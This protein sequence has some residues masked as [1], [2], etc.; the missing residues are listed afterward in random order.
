MKK[1]ITGAAYTDTMNDRE[2]KNRKIAYEA[3]TEGI[4]LLKNDGAL[5]VKPGR[6][7][8]YGAGV[9]QT[10]KG[11]TGSGEVYTRRDI[12]I[13]EG[14]EN[15]GFEVTTKTWIADYDKAYEEAVEAH[16]E[17]CRKAF[18]DGLKGKKS[19][20]AIDPMS[21]QI[22]LPF[23]RLIT[24]KDIADSGCDTAVYVVARQAG[25]GADKRLDREDFDLAPV[26]V[27]NLKMISASYKKTVLVI[28]SG[29]YM[30]LSSIENIPVSAL[31]FFC[32]QGT[33]G[34]NA[35]ASIV[36]GKVNPSGKLVDT[37]CA[38]YADIPFGDQYSYLSG[39]TTQEY[40]R[41]GIYVGYRYF[42]TYRVKPRYP[43]GFG[44]S[45]TEFKL[46]TAH[47]RREKMDIVLQVAVTN[48]G[49]V[50]G[51]EV[52]QVYVSC[53]DGMLKKEYQRLVAF[54]KTKLLQSGETQTLEIRFPM[55]YCA[56]YDETGAA[57][58]LEKGNYIIRVGN[59][60]VQTVAA[61]VVALDNTAVISQNTNICK[62][63]TPVEELVPV[64][65]E[66]EDDLTNAVRICLS[67]D[68]IVTRVVSYKAPEIYHDEQVDAILKKLTVKEMATLCNGAGFMSLF[69]A[70][71]NATPGA[72][73]SSTY[74]LLNKG[75]INVNFSDGPAGLRLQKRSGI[76]KGGTIKMIDMFM[77]FMEYIPE[78]IKK[79]ICANPEKD[80][81]VYQF[82][83]A[84]PVG[85]SIAQSW[86]TEIAAEIGR[87]VSEEMREY[88]VTFWLAP[89]MN[90]H[91]NPLCGRNYEYFS[92]DPVISGKMAAAIVRGVQSIPGNYATPKHFCCNN[93]ED[94][95]T[96]SNSNV[97]ERA[98]RE[99]YLRG[100]EICVREAAPKALMTSYNLINGVYSPNCY[101]TV[102]KVLRNEWGFNGMVVTDWMS[103]GGN[104]ARNDLAIKAGND[105]IGAG[106]KQN[107]K[108]IL[109][110]YKAGIISKED[111][112]RSCANILRAILHSDAAQRITPD[113]LK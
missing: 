26:E 19:E 92:E 2:I 98:L 86:N 82:C 81:V 48:I 10:I 62:R 102:T 85:S 20:D 56:S 72:V 107:A 84:F 99:I 46:Q 43:F 11:G 76:T 89:A 60:S 40:Y 27:E 94:N 14:M 64:V 55:D 71:K 53:P 87:A 31:I 101:D 88:N 52:A 7:A 4:V 95:R 28:N 110:G 106:S 37:W 68:E 108:E 45:Y 49:A 109:K 61:A 13:L 18:R 57:Y 91:R 112:E 34:G 35:F 70:K 3:A 63:E 73:G 8:L 96:H 65:R 75:L 113:M 17:R 44:L 5:P 39:D 79:W 16:A 58:I 25:E 97:N 29:S 1:M 67:A 24:E 51:K 47:V 69:M 74:K 59:S 21:E 38:D 103:T 111:L 9:S 32:Q 42:D 22:G 93:Q 30:N 12:S 66:N 33:E 23:G 36:S 100:F 6:I 41:E 78:F 15:A 77:S 80:T 83:T 54:Q 50:P 104:Q 90:I 105:W